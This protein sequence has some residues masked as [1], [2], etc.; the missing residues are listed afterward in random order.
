MSTEVFYSVDRWR[1]LTRNEEPH[2]CRDKASSASKL[3]SREEKKELSSPESFICD[4]FLNAAASW[5]LKP[6]FY[7]GKEIKELAHS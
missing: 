7:D 2:V 5:I 3:K 6:L 1:I 4:V